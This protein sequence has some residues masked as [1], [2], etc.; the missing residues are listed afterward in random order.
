MRPK[1]MKNLIPMTQLLLAL[2]VAVTLFLTPSAFAAA[3]GITGPTFNLTAQDAYLNQPDGEAVYSWGYGCNGAP[4][5]FAPAAIT[6]AV[7]NSMQVPGPTLIVHENDV[8]T[9]NLLNGL[10]TAA[11][12]TSILF[13]GF[14]VCAGTISGVS[15]T[16]PAGTCT[17]SATDGVTGLLTQ[18]AVPAGSVSYQFVATTPGTHA[19]YSGTQGDLQIEMGL[20]GAVIVLPATVP[21]NCTTGYHAGIT[22]AK[23]H[24]GEPDFRLWPAAYDHPGSCYDREYLFQWAE[25]DPR[26]H[27]QALAEVL[28]PT[29]VA[30]CAATTAA[31]PGCSLDVQTE[32][33]H[34]AYFVINGRSMPDLMDPNYASEYPH[35]PYNGNPHTHPGDLL[36]IRTIGQGRWQHPYHEHAN[37]V[38]ILARDGNLI[39][40]S[41]TT[42]ISYNTPGGTAASGPGLAG[43]LMFNTDTTPGDAFDGIFYFTG[44]G[45]NWDPYGHHPVS[46]SNDPLATLPCTPDV[47]GYN[48]QGAAVT[49]V[50]YFEW[51]QDH[52]KPVEANPFGDVAA[53]GPATLPDPNVFT[54]GAWYGG[55]PYFGPDASLRAAMQIGRAHV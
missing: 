49:A 18:E 40:S 14:Q 34:P 1:N 32:P 54:N 42:P 41:S 55:T 50:N 20:Y 6:G 39:L 25:M 3:P 48:T 7:C 21:A 4:A 26:I 31:K 36:L 38:R 51:C 10:P 29:R 28:D 17:P 13:P 22:T 23:A 44:R 24:W 5:G 45:L 2:M 12:N 15:S 9:V 11:G 47:N 37:H 53:G 46:S 35:Q 16:N 27:R 30:A 33:Y 43:L 19:Y 8:V 52:N